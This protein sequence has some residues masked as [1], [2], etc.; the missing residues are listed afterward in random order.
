MGRSV[1]TH[2]RATRTVFTTLY[3]LMGYC[4]ECDIDTDDASEC[5]ECGQDMYDYSGDTQRH[6]FEFIVDDV[7]ERFKD[8]FPSMYDCD[9]WPEDE[10]HAIVE[11]SHCMVVISEYCGMV[12]IGVV[13]KG[14]PDYYNDASGLAYHWT[15]NYAIQVLDS[16]D[17]YGKIGVFSNGE[18]VFERR[19]S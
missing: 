5:P 16:W 6:E 18:A 10:S 13:P 9:H 15:E 8:E 12:S 19:A 14:D 2:S 4:S 3:G 7:R 11:N 1:W 17:Q